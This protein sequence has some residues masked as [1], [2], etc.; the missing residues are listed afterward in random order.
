MDFKKLNDDLD[1]FDIESLELSTDNLTEIELRE[2]KYKKKLIARVKGSKR[3]LIVAASALIITA[4]M[5]TPAIANNIPI[6]NE[7]YAEL[8]IFDGYE[9]YREYI[10]QTKRVGIYEISIEDM[11]VFEDV[12]QIAIKVVS[13]EKLDNTNF[14]IQTFSGGSV[15]TTN[16]KRIDDYTMITTLA[17]YSTDGHIDGKQAFNIEVSEVKNNDEM[18]VR[19]LHTFEVKAD[20]NNKKG[21]MVEFDINETIKDNGS[22]LLRLT[23]NNASVRLE[24]SNGDTTERYRLRDELFELH[25][26]IYDNEGN[27]REGVSNK[28]LKKYE[29]LNIA[30]SKEESYD[31]A[32]K[33]DDK[34]Y[35]TNFGF[36][37]E[38]KMSHIFEQI[39]IDDI[40]NANS[41][42]VLYEHSGYVDYDTEQDKIGK[43][44]Y[45]K[46]IITKS[47][48][49]IEADLEVIGEN[50]IRINYDSDVIDEI[51]LAKHYLWYEGEKSKLGVGYSNNGQK[52]VEFEDVDLNREANIHFRPYS[53]EIN[54][55]KMIIKVK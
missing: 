15:G 34:I 42:E 29:E 39:N 31:L 25:D 36:G 47:G 28:Q 38:E 40:K 24:I 7:I 14:R 49:V 13:D 1:N 27:L 45:D 46:K 41:V 32:L 8:G 30:T 43:I 18:T 35:N 48:I 9:D 37:D 12:M 6:L 52:Y 51:D 16:L 33:V 20:F 50:K 44:T 2:M 4:G 23:A 11:M 10:G 26:K 19:S 55:T 5:C 22:Q 21:E 53:V 17:S 54:P 3:K